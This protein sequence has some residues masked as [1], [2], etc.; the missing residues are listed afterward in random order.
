MTETF[1]PISVRLDTETER[2]LRRLAHETGS[3]VSSVVRE[4]VAEY[5]AAHDRRRTPGVRPYDRLEH[6]IGVV[7]RHTDR[8]ERTGEKLRSALKGRTRARRAR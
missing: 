4:A 3:T 6:L 2:L 7:S 1:R 8:S 5:G